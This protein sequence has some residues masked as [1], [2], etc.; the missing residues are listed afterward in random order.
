MAPLALER[1]DEERWVLPGQKVTATKPDQRVAMLSSLDALFLL[2]R[3]VKD[4]VDATD[5]A[6]EVRGEKQLYQLG[7]SPKSRQPRID[8]LRGQ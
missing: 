2:R 4:F 8:W 7:S 1:F 5:A 3:N 6:R